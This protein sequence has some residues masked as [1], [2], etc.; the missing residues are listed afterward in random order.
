MPK[1]HVFKTGDIVFAKIKGY[2]HWPARVEHFEVEANGKPPK[3][4]YPVLFY[5]TLETATLKPDDL[6]PYDE[7]FIKSSKLLPNFWHFLIRF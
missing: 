6:F 4:K 7:N 3:N 5:G 1:N 2:P